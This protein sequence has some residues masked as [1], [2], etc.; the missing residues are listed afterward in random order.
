MKTFSGTLFSLAVLSQPLMGYISFN[1][2]EYVSEIKTPMQEK[3][4]PMQKVEVVEPDFRFQIGANYTYAT[5]QPHDHRTFKG[6]LGG[7]QAMFEYRPLNRFYGAAKLSWRQGNTEGPKGDRSILLFDTHERLGYTYAPEKKDWFLTLFSGVGYRYIGQKFSPK[8]GS[9]LLFNYDEFYIP[10]GILTNFNATSW[11]SIGLN[12]T[13]M[14]Q[15]YPTVSIIPLKGA[16][17]VL[18]KTMNNFYAEMPFTFYLTQNKRYSLII[19]PF[20]EHWQN[21]HTTAKL[22]NG[23]PLGLPANTYNFYGVDVNFGFTF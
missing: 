18:E 14:P 6:S 21:G 1:E 22:Q 11:L 16:R 7:M 8:T 4:Q 3:P 10:L 13:W 15:V 2:S 23:S 5:L 20:Y 12:Y 17:W 19:N 9:S